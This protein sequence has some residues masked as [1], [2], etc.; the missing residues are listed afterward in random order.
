M[1]GQRRGGFPGKGQRSLV[2]S[3][4]NPE[5]AKSQKVQVHTNQFKLKIGEKCPILFQ[6]PVRIHEEDEMADQDNV[7][8]FSVDE[9][10]RVVDYCQKKIE[11]LVGKFIHSGLNI[12]TTQQLM[13][14]S[15]L[16]ESKLNGRKITLVIEREG[17]FVVNPG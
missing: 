14:E 4:Q 17:E 2:A 6:Y 16:I 15:Y 5:E 1:G 9:I 8:K 12:W 13:E 10:T 7:H 3:S 11:L